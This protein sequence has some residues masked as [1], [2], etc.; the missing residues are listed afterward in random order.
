M[1]EGLTENNFFPPPNLEILEYFG[2]PGDNNITMNLTEELCSR[3][4]EIESLTI[5][6][7]KELQLSN[8]FGMLK[9]LRKVKFSSLNVTK[10]FENI[11]K[12]TQLT[13]LNL[14]YNQLTSLPVEIGQLTQ[15]TTLYLSGNQ[16]TS[17]PVEIGQLAQL[18]ELDLDYN[19]LA[20]L[21]VEIGNMTQLTKLDLSR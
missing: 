9:N 20:S 4:K 11:S 6:R 16:L 18:T 10:G 17:L 2:K 15:L 19:Q 5:E 21:P 1:E 14:S 13:G 8:E 7:V 3:L 12:L